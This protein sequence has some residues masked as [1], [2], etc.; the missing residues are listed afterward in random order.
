MY[1]EIP[2]TK[3]KIKTTKII[4]KALAVFQDD[5][6]RHHNI[7]LAD[8]SEYD[9]EIN[10]K[11]FYYP[12]WVGKIRT[13]KQRPIYKPKEI[14]YYVICDALDRSYIVL[15]NTPPTE[16]FK[17]EKKN[18]LP[19]IVNEEYFLKEIIEE[20]KIDRIDKQFIWGKPYKETKEHKKIYIPMYQIRIRKKGQR[21][22]KIYYA[23]QYTGEIKHG[24]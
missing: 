3:K 9:I 15:R 6:K 21:E 7:G 19:S 14:N 20:S 16:K 5:K 12:Y 1:I 18:M 4:K 13:V 24:I 2:A 11:S 23:N 22:Y 8:I 17:C 10:D